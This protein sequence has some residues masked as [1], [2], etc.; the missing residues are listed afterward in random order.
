MHRGA[1]RVLGQ[2]RFDRVF[3]L[4]DLAGDPV[5]GI[6]CAVGCELLQDPEA[7]PA[8][9]ELM[10]PSP[11]VAWTIRFC[12]MPL[13]RMLASSAASSRPPPG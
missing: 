9:I 7:A 12:R 4:L 13:A 1:D 10:T 5:I 2:R 11:S 8:G 3:G 6:D